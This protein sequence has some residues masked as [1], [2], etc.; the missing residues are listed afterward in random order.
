MPTTSTLRASGSQ[1]RAVRSASARISLRTARRTSTCGVT[2]TRTAARAALELPAG[3]H[4]AVDGHGLVAAERQ[5]QRLHLG[6]DD[7]FPV[8]VGQQGLVPA[9]EQ[10]HGEGRGLRRE[11]LVRKVQELGAA[12]VA[13]GHERQARQGLGEVP[14]G[15]AGP[16]RD[17]APA[18]RAERREVALH[19]RGRGVDGIRE[20]SRIDQEARAPA[21]AP[22]PARRE[23]HQRQQRADEDDGRPRLVGDT[24]VARHALAD[25][26]VGP[27]LAQPLAEL[28]GHALL[29]QA[30]MAL[31]PRP[32]PRLA[33]EL[34][35]GR[36]VLAGDEVERQAVDGGLHHV[37]RAD[38]RLERFTREALEARG[39]RDVRRGRVLRLERGEAADRLGGIEALPL[40]QH[41]PRGQRR[42]QPRAGK[43]LH[44]AVAP[45]AACVRGGGSPPAPAC[46]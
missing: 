45:T 29:V 15:H 43:R 12:L 33:G 46:A 10:A 19:H 17:V 1:K 8:G 3:G 32:H 5:V 18:G 40:E 11:R 16:G 9:A 6:R 26:A 13:V 36:V 30:G 7:P 2:T 42:R 41:L 14:L 21:V 38:R 24:L 25:L 20:R 27:R 35:V 31:A 28:G 22:R 23:L 34:G 4:A 39:Q 37:A 44:A